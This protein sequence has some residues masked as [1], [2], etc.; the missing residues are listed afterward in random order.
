M[1]REINAEDE[2]GGGGGERGS[3]YSEEGCGGSRASETWGRNEHME[4]DIH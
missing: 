4:V 1:K 3:T 2:G